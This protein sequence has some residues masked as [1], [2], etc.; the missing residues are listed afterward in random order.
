MKSYLF[1]VFLSKNLCEE[2]LLCK[3]LD[4]IEK[5]KKKIF[6]ELVVKMLSFVFQYLYI[7]KYYDV[8]NG[9]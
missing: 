5:M 4:E 3:R 9:E 8:K 1:I 2:K 7:V 6:C